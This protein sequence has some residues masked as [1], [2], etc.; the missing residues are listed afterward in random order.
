MDN[1]EKTTLIEGNPK[2]NDPETFFERL[3][4]EAK[5]AGGKDIKKGA[6]K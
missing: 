4:K 3:E 6:K 1:W 5:P 2:W